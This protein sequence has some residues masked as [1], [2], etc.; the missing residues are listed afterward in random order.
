M[1]PADHRGT[2]V[3]KRLSTG[4]IVAMNYSWARKKS[5]LKNISVFNMA[6]SY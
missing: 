2:C 1:K 5:L 4:R 3:F 6:E